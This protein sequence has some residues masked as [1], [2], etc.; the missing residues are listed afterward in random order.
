MARAQCFDAVNVLSVLSLLSGSSGGVVRGVAQANEIE[1]LRNRV[2]STMGRRAVLFAL[3]VALL[4]EGQIVDA[5][6]A[7]AIISLRAPSRRLVSDRR[8]CPP[9]AEGAGGDHK[10]GAAVQ[11]AFENDRFRYT[12]S[13]DDKS[14]DDKTKKWRTKIRVPV[15]A[16]RRKDCK[17]N[18]KNEIIHLG[19]QCGREE[20]VLAAK[21]WIDKYY[22]SWSS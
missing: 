21:R 5:F 17:K 8:A 4:A 22:I 7:P 19:A 14:D 9:R 13:D 6:T 18:R 12:F 10:W 2:K 3:A 15:N 16:K 11:Q 20:A 1:S